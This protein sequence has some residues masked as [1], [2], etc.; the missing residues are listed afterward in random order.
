[1]TDWIKHAE[2]GNGM[3]INTETKTLL[4]NVFGKEMSAYVVE[5][6]KRFGLRAAKGVAIATAD[7]SKDDFDLAVKLLINNALWDGLGGP[8][9]GWTLFPND[10]AQH[11]LTVW[12][13]DGP[14]NEMAKQLDEALTP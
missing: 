12:V 10:D 9:F 6:L 8:T 3:N 5:E 13:L 2:K 7:A 14:A 1:M 4:D 11:E